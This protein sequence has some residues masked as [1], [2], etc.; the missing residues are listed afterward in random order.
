MVMFE[1]Y[2]AYHFQKRSAV[3]VGTRRRGNVDNVKIGRRNIY[4]N[5]VQGC[6]IVRFPLLLFGD[7]AIRAYTNARFSH[8]LSIVSGTEGDGTIR[9]DTIRYSRFTCAQKL[10]RL[11]A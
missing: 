9:Y 11:P 10:T 5:I 4:V 7:R 2:L 1:I 6:P 3:P 8:S